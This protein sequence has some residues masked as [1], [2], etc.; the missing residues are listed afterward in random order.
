MK[1]PDYNTNPEAA[2]LFRGIA[3]YRHASSNAV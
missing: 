1:W 3:D 2:F